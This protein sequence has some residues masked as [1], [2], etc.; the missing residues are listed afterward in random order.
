MHLA[1]TKKSLKLKQNLFFTRNS[2]KSK[3]RGKKSG[4]KE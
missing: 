2:E 3:K 1:Q 4:L